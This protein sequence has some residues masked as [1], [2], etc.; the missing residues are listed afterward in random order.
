MA[1]VVVQRQRGRKRWCGWGRLLLLSAGCAMLHACKVGNE[2]LVVLKVLRGEHCDKQSSSVA[3]GRTLRN[4]VCLG[5][6]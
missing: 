3:N 5:K 6:S 2:D 1:V 4:E